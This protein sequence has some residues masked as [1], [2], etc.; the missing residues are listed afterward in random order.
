MRSLGLAAYAFTRPP[1]ARTRNRYG[2]RHTAGAL[3]LEC[4]WSVTLGG[5]MHHAWSGGGGGW[6]VF[7]DVVL[8]YQHLRLAHPH[9][10]RRVLIVDLDVHQVGDAPVE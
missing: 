9:R 8:S 5:G 1:T 6:C 2:H 7:A 10:V 4:G 3:A